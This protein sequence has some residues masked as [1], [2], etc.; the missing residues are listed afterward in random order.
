MCSAKTS[1]NH[2]TLLATNPGQSVLAEVG[3]AR[4]KPLAYTAYGVQSGEQSAGSHLGFNGQLRERPLGWYHLGHGRRIYSPVLMH[5]FSPD[6]LSPFEDGGLNPY[7]YCVGDPINL[8]DPTG[9]AP[10]FL[11]TL[12]LAAAGLG[13]FAGFFTFAAPK[14]LA[15]GA[16][17]SNRVQKFVDSNPGMATAPGGLD[18]VNTGIGSASAVL[19]GVGTIL[20]MQ[21]E[22]MAGSSEV[23]KAGLALGMT[24]AVFKIGLWGVPTTYSDGS[25]WR[26]MG[27]MFHGRK[28]IENAEMT[29]RALAAQTARSPT[30]SS[31]RSS[32]PTLGPSA[33]GRRSS[34]SSSDSFHSAS[35]APSFYSLSSQG[36]PLPPRSK[37]GQVFQDPGRSSPPRTMA[38]QMRLRSL[39]DR[40]RLN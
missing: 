16:K 5:F 32:S 22:P 30:P 4:V 10:D 20:N 37:W 34:S 17:H 8:G 28:K 29:Q 36:S 6:T 1:S 33:S 3:E 21:E 9:Q 19:G 23:M 26:S 11:Q 25:R 18:A 13:L 12:S 40:G 15:W 27:V 24:S 2:V 7:G 35:S 38:H 39:R 31:T 14:L